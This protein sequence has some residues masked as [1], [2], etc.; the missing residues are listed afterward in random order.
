MA[1]RKKLG[2]IQSRGL[3]DVVIALPIAR[4][5]HDQ[6]WDVYWPICEEFIPNFK[7]TVPWVRWVPVTTDHGPFFYDVP[8]QRLRNLGCD[9]IICLYQAL[10]GHNF[11]DEKYFQYTKFDQYKYIQAGV[12]F[13]NKWQ[14]ADCITRNPDREQALYD[15]VITNPNYVVLHLEG[16]DARAEFDTTSVPADWQQVEIQPHTDCIFDWLKIIEGAQ[17]VVMIDS[18]YA[19]IVDQMALGE[20]RYFIQRSHIGLT[21]VQGQH[22]NWIA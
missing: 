11:H 15:R 12:P 18:V 7:D 3:G 21:P 4:Y 13:L 1:K 14:L 2:L 9:E 16:S 22:W 8:M 20:D 19:N 5:Y 6:G 10:T 17:S